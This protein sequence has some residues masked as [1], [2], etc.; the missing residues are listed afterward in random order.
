MAT[1]YSDTFKYWF[2]IGNLRVKCG[3]TNDLARREREHQNSGRYTTHNGT[4][5]YWSNGRIV[6]DGMPVTRESALQ[7]EKDNDCND[8]LG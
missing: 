1:T 5:Y 3:I 6:Q 8:N 2:K 4:R 7:W